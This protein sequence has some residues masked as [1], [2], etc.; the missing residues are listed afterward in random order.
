M[1]NKNIRYVTTI[2]ALDRI[3]NDISI[4]LWN[5]DDINYILSEQEKHYGLKMISLKE[6]IFIEIEYKNIIWN[7]KIYYASYK[8]RYRELEYNDE[9]WISIEKKLIEDLKMMGIENIKDD[10]L[11][12]LKNKEYYE[13]KNKI[14]SQFKKYCICE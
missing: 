14:D 12:A 9:R 5:N 11:C 10:I 7:Y 4:S 13:Y 2:F 6:E 3:I 8:K 1:D